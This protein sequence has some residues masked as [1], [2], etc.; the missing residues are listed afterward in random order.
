MIFQIFLLLDSFKLCLLGVSEQNFLPTLSTFIV[1][2]D[3]KSI[4]WVPSHFVII[5]FFFL[6]IFSSASNFA[7]APSS[8]DTTGFQP[9]LLAHH[10]LWWMWV[11]KWL[12]NHYYHILQLRELGHI[13]DTRDK[14]G[15]IIETGTKMES[16]ISPATLRGRK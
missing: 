12:L 1:Q 13:C 15:N 2:K 10:F 4:F 7:L 5:L 3:Y 16:D 8:P 14:V 6:P 9:S 11:I